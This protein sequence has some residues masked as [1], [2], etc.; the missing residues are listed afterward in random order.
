MSF[1][2]GGQAFDIPPSLFNLGRVKAKST[3]CVGAIVASDTFSFWVVG[4]VFL[5]TVYTEFDMGNNV[6]GFATLK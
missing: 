4:D 3:Q 5:Q 6:V 2:F 1:T